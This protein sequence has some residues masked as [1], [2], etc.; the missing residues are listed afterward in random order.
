[1]AALFRDPGQSWES[2]ALA[3]LLGADEAGTEAPLEIQIKREG[4]WT[5]VYWTYGGTRASFGMYWGGRGRDAAA[6]VFRPDPVRAAGRA[7]YQS[8]SE[9][10]KGVQVTLASPT[11]APVLP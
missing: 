10:T 2:Q 8:L 6:L 7:Q 1:V 9:I 4:P 11:D 5:T 3:Y